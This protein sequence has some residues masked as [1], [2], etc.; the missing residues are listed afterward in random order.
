MILGA[1]DK[2][3]WGIVKIVFGEN[4]LKREVTLF[5]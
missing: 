3:D 4:G 1:V 5:I 2:L